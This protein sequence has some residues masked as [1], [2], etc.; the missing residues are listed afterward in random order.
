MD[1]QFEISFGPYRAVVS[2][3]GASLRGFTRQLANGSE[4][5]ILWG[6]S[7]NGNKKGGQGDV[8][9]PFPGRVVGGTYRFGS[10]RHQLKLNDKDGP[11][12]IHGFLRTA[13]WEIESRESSHVTFRREV[14][15]DEFE[16][17]PFALSVRVSYSLSVNGLETRFEIINS[18]TGPAP[19]GAGFHP[20][21]TVGTDRIDEARLQFRSSRFLEFGPGLLP[22]GKW[23]ATSGSEVDFSTE[24]Q[25]GDL[26]FNHCF[27]EL[28]RDLNGVARIRL[29]HPE[30]REVTLWMDGSFSYLVLYTGDTIP[31]TDARRALAIEPMTCA[32]DAFNRLDWGLVSLGPG[33]SLWGSFGV[34]DSEV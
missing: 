30:N 25:I 33:E 18:G 8:L 27:A 24:R 6:Y 20:Y 28:E 11:N 4:R 13:V 17:Y 29:S 3:Q 16:G 1:E 12:A 10:V 32:T 31:G 14:A 34:G 19:V 23:I 9:I 26:Q 5:A 22:T 21:F 2:A 15:A 7:G